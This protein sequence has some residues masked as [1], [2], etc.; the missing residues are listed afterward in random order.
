MGARRGPDP[1][2]R[3]SVW[4]LL[5]GVIPFHFLVVSFR[6]SNEIFSS[7]QASVQSVQ[8]KATARTS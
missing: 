7:V 6:S 5:K 4:I 3:V 1:K 8:R 2:A